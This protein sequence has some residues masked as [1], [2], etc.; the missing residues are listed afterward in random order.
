LRYDLLITDLDGTLVDLGIDW[1]Q[2]RDRIRRE[3][4]WNHPL[5]PLGP[6]IPVAAGGD[7]E[8]IEAAFKIVEIA[9]IEAAMRAERDEKLASSLERLRGFGL[10][11]GLVTLQALK[12]A[13]TAL[14][15]LGVLEFFDV[16]VTRE[17]SLSREEQLRLAIEKLRGTPERSIFVGDTEMDLESSRRIG[18]LFV[19]VGRR[20]SWRFSAESFYQVPDLVE[21]IMVEQD[22]FDH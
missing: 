9:E 12:P 8:K 18:C 16:I 20:V 2:L 21:A 10:R 22:K 4:G 11:I 6:S 17:I 19:S 7:R 1:D 13:L 15:R 5:K 14:R 3:M